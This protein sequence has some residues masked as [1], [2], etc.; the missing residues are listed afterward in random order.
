MN[1][2]RAKVIEKQIV[3]CPHQG[4][5]SWTFHIEQNIGGR[6]NSDPPGPRC[7][8]VYYCA[9]IN[10]SWQQ[11]SFRE[12]NG[13]VTVRKSQVGLRHHAC[14]VSSDI[15]CAALEVGCHVELDTYFGGGCLI[16]LSKDFVHQLEL[17]G[18]MS[19]KFFNLFC[20]LNSCGLGK[21]VS[22][23]K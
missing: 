1:D 14:D 21:V 20:V 23:W 15:S 3:L 11:R 19:S 5:Q 18:G 8:F 6:I 7:A 16:H 12:G 9:W 4:L 10:D 13:N 2:W 22:H 17:W